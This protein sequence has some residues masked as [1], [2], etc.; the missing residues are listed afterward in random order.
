M[1]PAAARLVEGLDATLA[2]AG[3]MMRCCRTRHVSTLGRLIRLGIAVAMGLTL[4]F[5]V[6]VSVALVN[7]RRRRSSSG[8]MLPTTFGA[9]GGGGPS[10]GSSYG[11]SRP[12]S[13]TQNWSL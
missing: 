4:L 1:L 9:F 3:E 13:R 8:L 6:G 7:G 10:A 2:E 11:Y 12:S 5:A